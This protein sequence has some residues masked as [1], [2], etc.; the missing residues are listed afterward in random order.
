MILKGEIISIKSYGVFVK[1]DDGYT[2]LLHISNIGTKYIKDLND[3]FKVN[4]IIYVKV[5][6]KNEKKKQYT[7]STMDIDFNTGEKFRFYNNGFYILK[8]NLSK[9]VDEK[10]KEYNIKVES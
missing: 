6:E 4:S 2:G 3:Y 10:V 7:L 9:W 8:K 1:F 5:I